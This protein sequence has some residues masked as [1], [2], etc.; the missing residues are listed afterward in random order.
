MLNIYLRITSFKSL[1]VDNK[2]TEIRR[3]EYNKN[4]FTITCVLVRYKN[5]FPIKLDTSAI[6]NRLVECTAARKYI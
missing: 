6:E 3:S 1:A 5:L 2:Y 4:D